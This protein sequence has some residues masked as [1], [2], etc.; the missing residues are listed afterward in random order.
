MLA[1][2]WY[3]DSRLQEVQLDGI[4]QPIRWV[5]SKNGWFVPGITMDSKLRSLKRQALKYEYFLGPGILDLGLILYVLHV[6]P[7]STLH[8]ARRTAQCAMQVQ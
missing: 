4:G 7:S 8:Q 1:I 2:R 5:D 6:S 3:A